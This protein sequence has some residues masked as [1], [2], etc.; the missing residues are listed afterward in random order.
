MKLKYSIV[1]LLALAATLVSCEKEADH[2][3][4]E[5][6]VSSSYVSLPKTGGDAEITITAEGPW[7][8]SKTFD[9]PT[10]EKDDNGKDITVKKVAPAWLTVTPESGVAG[11]ATIKFHAEAPEARREAVLVISCMGKTQNINIV[12]DAEAA[13]KPQLPITPIA[14]VMAEGEGTWR[15]RGTVTKVVNDQ[16]GNFYMIDDSYN[17]PDFQIYGTKN[18]K[19]Q[20]PKEAAGGWASFGIEAGD[21]VTVEGPYSLYKTTHELVDVSVIAIDGLEIS[22]YTVPTLST[23]VQ[24]AEEMGRETIR[25]LLSVLNGGENRHVRLETSFRSGASIRTL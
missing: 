11:E 6:K 24:P 21:I 13:E 18:E 10:G 16:Y 15:V 23:M 7:E 2:Y 9:V 1:S 22:A 5:M 20:Y 8:F 12:Q 14:T 3:L 19:G 4:S 25:L 17:G